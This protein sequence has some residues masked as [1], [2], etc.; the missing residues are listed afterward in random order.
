MAAWALAGDFEVHL[1]EK[2]KMCGQKLL[3]AGKGG[4]NLSK[5]L[6]LD[7]FLSNYSPPGFLDEAI[8]NFGLD[9]LRAWLAGINIPTFV[10]SSGKIFPEKGISP[11]QVLK[12]ILEELSGKGVIFHLKH[13]L[14]SFAEDMNFVFESPDGM[15]ASKADFAVLAFGGAS[16]PKTGSDGEWVKLF[17]RAGINTRAFQPSN[18]GINIAWPESVRLHHEGKP[19]KN[20]VV[21]ANGRES[22]GEATRLF[23]SN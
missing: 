21:V 8:R 2:E 10:G 6:P 20:I 9:E 23:N 14:Q 1:F 22:K 17:K 3:L 11:A 4:L 18:C 7:Q 5:N 12:A 15:L 19:L 13:R 16:W